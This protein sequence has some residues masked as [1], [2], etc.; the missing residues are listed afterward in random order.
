MF[1]V[2][3][4]KSRIDNNL[5]TGY[6]SDL[7]RRLSEHNKKMNRSTKGRTPLDLLYYEAYTSQADAKLRES[8]I[9][10]SAGAR[11]ALKRRLTNC[12]RSGHFV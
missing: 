2:Y 4:L 7:R 11:T 6:T 12:L 1:Y 8:R 5:Y 9:K 3:I 10:H